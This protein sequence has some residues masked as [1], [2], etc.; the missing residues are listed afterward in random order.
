MLKTSSDPE[1]L[2]WERKR[3]EGLVKARWQAAGLIFG[4]LILIFGVP[5]YL[6]GF[7]DDAGMLLPWAKI[8]TWIS[9]LAGMVVYFFGLYWVW[10]T[11]RTRF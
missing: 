1:F 3:R 5:A 4:S 9:Y 6:A 8:V 2:D 7:N 10:R 11:I